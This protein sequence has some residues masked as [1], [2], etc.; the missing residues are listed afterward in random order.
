MSKVI[1]LKKKHRE[2]IEKKASEEYGA[3]RLGEDSYLIPANVVDTKNISLDFKDDDMFKDN[4]LVKSIEQL[5][6]NDGDYLSISCKKLLPRNKKVV[7]VLVIGEEEIGELT[8]TSDLLYDDREML[9]NMIAYIHR[10]KELYITFYLHYNF[11]L[12]EGLFDG[13]E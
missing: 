13:E 7:E 1:D 2:F 4:K 8:I 9:L 12:L 5:E 11:S 3:V 6:V 10:N